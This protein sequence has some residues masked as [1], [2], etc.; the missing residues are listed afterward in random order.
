MKLNALVTLSWNCDIN[1]DYIM[2]KVTYIIY[3]LPPSTFGTNS[4]ALSVTVFNSNTKENVLK[5]FLW[6]WKLRRV[7][8]LDRYQELNWHPASM[9]SLHYRSTR[10]Q[11]PIW[12]FFVMTVDEAHE[13]TM[14]DIVVN[15]RKPVFAHR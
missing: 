13:Q 15:L 9:S 10:R 5:P 6:E 2:V 12:L 1:S 14:S 7:L 11:S 3:K 4:N 8:I